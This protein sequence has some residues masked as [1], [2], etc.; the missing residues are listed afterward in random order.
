[1][2]AARLFHVSDLH[3]GREDPAA[4]AWFAG[5]VAAE[6]PDA[7]VVTGDFTFRA[8]SA[9]FA[10]AIA[11]LEGLGVPLSL[12]PGNHDL[13]YYSDPLRRLFRPYRRFKKFEARIERPLALPGVTVVPL[14]TVSRFQWR[15][16]QSQGIVRPRSLDRALA[17]IAAAPAGSTIVVACHHPLADFAEMAHPQ[18]T[19][20]GGPALAAL[21]RAGV[22]AVLSGHVHD[23]FDQAWTGTEPALRLIGAGTLS[24]RVRATPPSFNELVVGNGTIENRV[25]PMK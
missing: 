3:F 19:R 9:E 7:V 4:L 12:E 1:M 15:L 24:A 2:A 20:G 10:A 25:R 5:V 18:R 14:H 6:R 21:A 23:P 17:A 13:P 11:Y 16:N 8:R 22:R